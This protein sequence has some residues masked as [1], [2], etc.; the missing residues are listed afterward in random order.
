MLINAFSKSAFVAILSVLLLTTFS[1][2]KEIVEI[3]PSEATIT[4]VPKPVSISLEMV[5]FDFVQGIPRYADTDAYL[6]AFEAVNGASAQRFAEWAEQKGLST[7]FHKYESLL[8]KLAL[9]PDK[10]W[11]QILSKGEQTLFLSNEDSIV[12]LNPA[13]P[14]PKLTNDNSMLFIGDNLHYFSPSKHI[15]V[16]N[17]TV[18]DIEA[19]RNRT[20]NYVMDKEFL[21]EEI[22]TKILSPSTEK[23]NN[24]IIQCPL[25]L[26][27][28]DDY[29]H[30]PTQ[31]YSTT[32]TCC[33]GD[34]DLPTYRYQG[35]VLREFDTQRIG[36]DA[37]R[38]AHW[39]FGV[40]SAQTYVTE[41][42]GTHFSEV[43]T[44]T[45]HIV[46]RRKKRGR[47][48]TWVNVVMERQPYNPLMRLRMET[49]Y[50]DVDSNER[51]IRLSNTFNVRI[52]TTDEEIQSLH[53]IHHAT[54]TIGRVRRS[55]SYEHSNVSDVRSEVFIESGS[56]GHRWTNRGEDMAN[57]PM[58]VYF[59]CL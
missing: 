43:T 11:R 50:L 36:C 29:T 23:V 17:G 58:A 12:Y 7:L 34:D 8:D 47:Q 22:E 26:A 35:T 14:C 2:T 27:S 6:Q 37:K 31:T 18:A 3:D 15:V 30:E 10:P 55:I 25:R 32:P 52:P 24:Q 42:E 38:C 46:N 59:I 4:E 19:I 33:G 54:W 44:V 28:S 1:C 49:S 57:N 51:I 41:L 16:K 45:Y 48:K 5:N 40:I 53:D 13:Y 9:E 20:E 39:T 21:I 56:L